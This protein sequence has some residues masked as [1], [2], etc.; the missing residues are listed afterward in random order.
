MRRLSWLCLIWFGSCAATATFAPTTQEGF[1]ARS[2]HLV[3]L[4][5]GGTPPVNARRI[6]TL[7]ESTGSS[8]END[9]WTLQD[10]GGQN[11]CELVVIEKS[12]DDRITAGCYVY[13]QGS[14][15]PT[16]E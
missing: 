7:N 8:E 11:G 6:G 3:Q 13:Q 14:T 1:A 10:V 2:A 12:M 9:L 15:P 5:Q 4:Q 16:S